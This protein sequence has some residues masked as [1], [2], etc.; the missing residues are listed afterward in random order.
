[1]NNQFQAQSAAL[2][3]SQRLVDQLQSQVLSTQSQLQSLNESVAQLMRA[4]VAPVAAV[5]DDGP[6]S[7]PLVEAIAQTV[8]FSFSPLLPSVIPQVKVSAWT[9]SA[10]PPKA[11]VVVPPASVSAD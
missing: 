2:Q 5:F 8:P 9:Y 1:M 7:S 11:A 3:A 10:P 6:A 4:P